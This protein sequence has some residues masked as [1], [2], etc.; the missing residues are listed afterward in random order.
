MNGKAMTEQ[1]QTI[2]TNLPVGE[3]KGAGQTGLLTAIALG[4][5]AANSLLCRLA[6]NSAD[7]DPTS[8]TTIRLVAGATMLFLLSSICGTRSAPPRGNWRSAVWLFLYALTFS[9]AYVGLSAGTGALILFAAVQL[10]MILTVVLAGERPGPVQLFGIF[11]TLSGLVY[12]LL[13]GLSAPTPV[14]ALLMAVAGV[15]W[16]VYS[17]RGRGEGDPMAATTGN[18]LRAAALAFIF[19]LILREGISISATSV[20]LA[21]ASGALASGLGYVVWYAALGGLTATQAAVVQLSVPVITAFGGV[22]LL[23]EELTSRLVV[24]AMVIIAGIAI[25]LRAPALA[26]RRTAIGSNNPGA[27]KVRRTDLL[28]TGSS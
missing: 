1:V 25:T 28:K 9:F 5:F 24:S 27:V 10:T 6:L 26:R 4:A 8:F 16:G 23:S 22:S 11:A 3:V 14:S 18:F 13:P 20:V 15:S 12:L 7:A 17:L 19:A 21:A 2:S